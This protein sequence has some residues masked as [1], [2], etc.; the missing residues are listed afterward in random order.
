[1]ATNNPLGNSFHEGPLGV[2]AVTFNAI[3]LGKTVDEIQMEFIEDIQDIMYAQDGTQ[4]YD[5]IPSGQAYQITCIFGQIDPA[6]L[7]QL[8]RGVTVSGA[9][10]SVKHG[11]DIYRSG[12]DN[13][14]KELT[15]T[16]VDSDGNASTNQFY[17]ATFYKAMPVITSSEIFGPETQRTLEVQFYCFYDE[18]KEAFFYTGHASSLGL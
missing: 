18:T 9:G 12:R 5:K 11:R 10:K 17:I 16:R 4:P 6:L 14:A 1:M 3:D 8:E 2:C 7:E 13:F 15:L